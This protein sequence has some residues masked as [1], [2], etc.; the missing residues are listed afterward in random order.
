MSRQLLHWRRRVTGTKA[1]NPLPPIPSRGSCIKLERLI[2]Q[3]LNYLGFIWLQHQVPLYTPLKS[4]VCRWSQKTA[5]GISHN[6]CCFSI[7]YTFHLK[8]ALEIVKN[9]GKCGIA[10]FTSKKNVKF[11]QH[12]II[13]IV[14]LSRSWT[15]L[16]NVINLCF[17][18]ADYPSLDP[19]NIICLLGEGLVSEWVVLWLIF[20]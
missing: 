4:I 10:L 3:K 13:K 18:S 11:R 1:F 15:P 6:C 16:F 19:F 14:S 12:D 9:V 17:L 2:Q 8:F 5:Y 7:N 20:F